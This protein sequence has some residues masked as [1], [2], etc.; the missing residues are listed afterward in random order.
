M[1]GTQPN[2]AFH[3]TPIR[4]SWINQIETWFAIITKQAIRRGTFAS[5]DALI[6]RIRACVEHRNA[7]AAPFV[8]TD[9]AHVNLAKVRLVQTSVKKL[10]QKTRSNANGITRHWA[11]HGYTSESTTVSC[12]YYSQL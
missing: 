10:V 6:A 3:F 1:A 2:V 9:T 8:W 5:V 4:S 12:G 11:L 7:N